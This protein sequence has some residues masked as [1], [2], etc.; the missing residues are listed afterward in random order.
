MRELT[1]LIT[2]P[3]Q[4]AVGLLRDCQQLGLDALWVPVIK[5]QPVSMNDTISKVIDI[6]SIADWAIFTSVN[7]IDCA[8][9]FIKARYTLFPAGLKYACLGHSSAKRLREFGINHVLLPSKAF[10]SE[11]LLDALAAYPLQGSIIGLLTGMNGREILVEELVRR[12][13]TLY[14]AEIYRRELIQQV[15]VD[16]YMQL[17]LRKIGVVLISSA[18]ILT[19]FMVLYE[20][21]II[22]NP[23]MIFIVASERIKIRGIALGLSADAIKVAESAHDHSMIKALIEWQKGTIS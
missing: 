12:G 19:H 2:R 7:A 4:Q 15:D 21:Q 6:L 1:V 5:I 16:K 20:K 22:A 23:A 11:G 9:P 8:M 10:T 17:S 14:L 13:A 18:E 3:E